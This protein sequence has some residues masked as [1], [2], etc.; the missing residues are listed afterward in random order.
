MH[1]R[2][3]ARNLDCI[4][5]RRLDGNC[6]HLLLHVSTLYSRVKPAYLDI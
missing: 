4:G 1:R 5:C 2:I 6:E 3:L